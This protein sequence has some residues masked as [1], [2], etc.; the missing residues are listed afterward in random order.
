MKTKLLLLV[1]SLHVVLLPIAAVGQKL[2]SPPAA[3][4]DEPVARVRIIAFDSTGNLLGPPNVTTFEGED[5][6]NIAINFHAGVAEGV[7]FGLYRVEARLPAYYAATRYARVYQRDVTVVVGLESGAYEASPIPLRL[8]GRVIGL[9]A[10]AAGNG[11]VRLIGVFSDITIESGIR[12][13]GTFEISG[14]PVG[15]Y[16]LLV[17]AEKA[18]LASKVV[19][20]PYAGPR[21]QI[22]IRRDHAVGTPP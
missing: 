4:A 9:P 13:E 5:R 16:V 17:V 3:Q 7:P 15:R 20:I 14:M 18:I 12:S 21:L 6:R 10:A 11:F 1:I 19:T 22:E 8:E 2:L